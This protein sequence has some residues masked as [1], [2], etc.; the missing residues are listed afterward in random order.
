LQGLKKVFVETDDFLIGAGEE[1]EKH[2]PAKHE[3]ALAHGEI[4]G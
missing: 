4:M 1:D 2:D 3:E